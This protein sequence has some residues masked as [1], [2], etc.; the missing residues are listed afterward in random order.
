MKYKSTLIACIFSISLYAQSAHPTIP[1]EHLSIPG[2]ISSSQVNGLLQDNHGLLWIAGD[3]LFR[4]DGY[5][6]THYRFLHTGQNIGGQEI[7]CLFKNKRTEKLLIG[8][9]SFGLAEYDYKTDKIRAIPS[10]GGVPIITSISQTSDGTVWASSFSNGLYFLDGDTLKKVSDPK[11]Q[12]KTITSLLS[13]G[14]RLY[15]DKQKRIYI[16]ENKTIVDSIEIK[17]PE[18][19]LPPHTRVTK[20]KLDQ[21][22]KI[23]MGTERAGVLVFD[24]T[25]REFV[26]YYS[27]H[28][29]PFFSRINDIL[30]DSLKNVWVLTKANGVVVINQ[31]TDGYVHITK[32][33]MQ[34][35]SISGNN[36]TSI[37][38]D[39]TGIIWIGSTGD[40]NKYDPE[41]IK[42][43]HIYNNPFSPVSLNDNMVRGVYEDSQE[44]LWVGTDGGIVHIFEK[45]KIQVEKVE[46]KLK[47]YTQRIIPVNFLELDKNT[48]LVGTSVGLL[49][50]DRNKKTFDYFKPLESRTRNRQVRQ[51]LRDNDYLYLICGGTIIIYNQ[52]SGL[53]KSFSEFGLT[54][55]AVRNATS[56]Y[57]D[58]KKRLWVGASNGLSLYNPTL[59]TF[60][61][62]PFELNSSRP[63]GTYFMI[64]SLQEY[65]G[66][67]WVGTFNSGLWTF[68][69]NDLDKPDIK[70]ITD[71]DGLPNNTVYSTIPDDKGNL[72]ISTNRGVAKYEIEK[73]R[74]TNFSSE[75]GLQQEEFNR[76]A[77]WRCASGDIVL[78][79]INGLNI[80]NPKNIQVREDNYEPKLSGI[81][82]FSERDQKNPFR[83]IINQTSI[84]L[85]YDQNNLDVSFFVPNFRLPRRFEVYY[86]LSGY[87]PEWQK[88]ETSIIHYANLKPGEYPLELKTI[89]SAGVEKI[90]TFTISIRHPFWQKWWFLMLGT[91]MIFLIAYTIIRNNIQKAKRDKERLERLLS[92]RTKEIEKSREELSILNQKKDFIFSILSHDLRSPLTTLKGFLSLLIDDAG[93]TKEDVQKHAS[94]IRNSVTGALDLIDNT[95]FWSLSQTGT[96]TFEP[97]PFFLNDILAKVQD[98]YSLTATRKQIMFTVETTGKIIVNGDENMVYVTLR[99]IV[100]NALKF[101]PEG[102]SV[103]IIASQYHPFAEIAIHDE[104]I[105]MSPAYI[106]KLLSDD[107]VSI[108]KGTSNEKGTG[109]GLVLCKKFIQMNNGELKVKSV[110][111]SGTQFVVRL[112][113]A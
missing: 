101:T 96:I 63:L 35:R 94:N 3:G 105:G 30:I 93:L 51:I 24:T 104:G 12:F 16:L 9:H 65:K 70:G 90:S 4:Y 74:F 25:K 20:M 6:F 7:K 15:T 88:A 44:K 99:N 103:K 89:S 50:F 26:K 100:S 52:K 39:Q 102:K 73:N 23:W 49:Q 43:K 97:S 69:L 5:K 58:S 84:A 79:G 27:P 87:D 1:F 68:D 37:I 47:N 42:F 45:K 33:P 18:V 91:A 111:G 67:L 41:K 78:G 72:W 106:E 29:T 109:L 8:T 75:D 83:G 48:M 76:L 60:R 64:L 80:F 112:P 53:T 107:Q 62:F 10:K 13:I 95:L 2:T 46:V 19:D 14:N 59:D 11:N 57:I 31:A 55:A 56:I 54:P 28:N 92:E 36:C 86:K 77:Y 85:D 110:E 21:K 32:N 40:L 17:Y 98:L 38:Q 61:H 71:S 22:G 34:E 81:S 108:K 82:I 66:K 113:L